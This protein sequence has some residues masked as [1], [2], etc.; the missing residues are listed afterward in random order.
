[1]ELF[2][3]DDI[4]SIEKN[5]LLIQIFFSQNNSFCNNNNNKNNIKFDDHRVIVLRL[6]GNPRG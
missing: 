4:M 2:C 5:N 1:M 6:Y 3:K